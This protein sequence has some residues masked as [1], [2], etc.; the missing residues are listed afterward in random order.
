[1]NVEV[2]MRYSAAESA[3]EVATGHKELDMKDKAM[4]ETSEEFDAILSGRKTAFFEAVE[5]FANTTLALVLAKNPEAFLP[6][7]FGIL[8][9]REIATIRMWALIQMEG[10]LDFLILPTMRRSA[11]ASRLLLT[12]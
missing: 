3:Y 1:M 7:A 6:S 2:F 5:E 8:G 11:T 10:A 12:V 4:E 9:L